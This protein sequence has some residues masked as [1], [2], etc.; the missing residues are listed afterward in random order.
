VGASIEVERKDF[1]GDAGTM[2]SSLPSSPSMTKP[3]HAIALAISPNPLGNETVRA[4]NE[5]NNILDAL[6]LDAYTDGMSTDKNTT[7]TPET[8][9]QAVKMFADPAVAL[10]FM[11]NLR[12]P[13]GVTCPACGSSRVRFISTRS[14]WECRETHA[15]KRF[16]IKTG[17]VMEDSPLPLEKWLMVMWLE[18]NA[19]NSVSSY[20]V[21]RAIGVTQKSAW[22]M[23]QRVR[24]AMQRGGFDKLG[25][26]GKIVEA[27]ETYIGGKARNMHK[28]DRDRKIGKNTGGVGKAIVMGLLERHGDDAS[29]VRTVVMN[30]AR[31]A[32]IHPVIR[33]NVEA[34]SELHTDALHSYQS[35]GADFIHKFIDHAETYVKDNVHTNSLENFWSLLKR[36]IKGT[37]VSIEPFHLFRYLDA[38]SFRFNNRKANDG[39]R[40]VKAIAGITGKRLTYKALTGTVEYL[41]VANVAAS[42]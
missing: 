21:H 26:K 15:K 29:V 6:P 33:E 42:E 22:F 5:G 40:L 37:H 32:D 36:A 34:G 18:A 28:K 39:Q 3:M 35:L 16:S 8:L 4:S 9:M 17:T 11:V 25:G 20:E 10:A 14:V 24:L 1:E 2:G 30:R 38:Q 13:N 19:K 23:Q 27:D 12:W 41:P 7:G 31:K